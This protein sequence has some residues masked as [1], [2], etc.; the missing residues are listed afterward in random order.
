M[1]EEIAGLAPSWTPLSHWILVHVCLLAKQTRGFPHFRLHLF[2][3]N[4]DRK[5]GARAFESVL[6]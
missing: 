5:E 6:P 2:F 4:Q 1:Q 3:D